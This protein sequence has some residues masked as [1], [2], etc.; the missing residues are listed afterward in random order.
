MNTF[1]TSASGEWL[2]DT[3]LLLVD[4]NSDN[5]SFLVGLML[6]LVPTMT[7]LVAKDGKQALQILEKKQSIIDLVLLDWEMPKMN[8]LEVLKVMEGH[9]LWQYIPTIMYTGA[10]T[11]VRHLN[12]ALRH[13]AIDFLRKPAEPVELLARMR[14]AL[15]QKQLEEQRRKV[16]Q[17]LIQQQN[18][19]LEKS[20][21][22]LRKETNDYL[23]ML[24][25]KNEVLSQIQ[26]Q[27]KTPTEETVSVFQRA[28]SRFVELSV[29]EDDYWE[30]FLEKL[31]QT[32]PKFV[33]E[34]LKQ[35]PELSKTEVKVCALIRFGI[36]NKSIANLLQISAD[37]VKKS[38]Y[39]I[40]KKIVLPTEVKLD[41]YI[42]SIRYTK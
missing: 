24:A 6:E 30:G 22:Q 18:D 4:D 40:R 14:S 17:Q 39:R 32:D 42:H 1:I 41:T 33:Q 29:R 12:E 31:N 2:N 15:R 37:G 10:M 11:D 27:C 7:V 25:R 5:R 19:F 36:D 23:L 3:T 21:V 9:L 13:G 34:L 20:N 28:M 26:Q 38:R 16:E 35:H 8:G